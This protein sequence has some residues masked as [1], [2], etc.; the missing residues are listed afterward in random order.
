M[1]DLSLVP[2]SLLH[3]QKADTCTDSTAS[4]FKVQSR[5]EDQMHV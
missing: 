3:T 4:V 1:S 2:I 5:D